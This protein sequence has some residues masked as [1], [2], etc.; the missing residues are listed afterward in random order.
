MHVLRVLGRQRHR[1]AHALARGSAD[2]GTRP[3]CPRLS[4]PAVGVRRACTRGV[5]GLPRRMRASAGAGDSVDLGR[6]PGVG[7]RHLSAPRRGRLRRPGRLPG[8]LRPRDVRQRAPQGQK[9]ELRL[10]AGRPRPRRRGRHAPPRPGRPA[11]AALRLALRRS[12]RRRPRSR[13]H[14]AVVAVRGVG[15]TASTAPGRRR[16]RTGRSR[17]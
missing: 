6:G 15:V 12:R 13:P 8:D 1:Q 14:A 16:L 5:Q 9:E 4:P 2:R 10:A 7:R 3:A 17:R 11:R